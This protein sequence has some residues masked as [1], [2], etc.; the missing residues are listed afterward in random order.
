MARGIA[1]EIQA[2]LTP[3]EQARLAKARPVNPVAYEA[4][5]RGRLLWSKWSIEEA[6]KALQYFQQ[7]VAID[8]NY[9]QAY[10]GVSD[11]YR[12]LALFGGPKPEAWQKAKAAAIRAVE[13][14]ETL[15]EAHRSLAPILL[16]YD[17]D[18]AAS[19]REN[20]RALQLNPGDAETYRVYGNF[21]L[22]TGQLNEAI[23]MTKHAQELDPLSLITGADLG[24]SYYFA[25]RYD[26][27][28]KQCRRVVDL[29]PNFA[30]AHLW[31]GHA[32]EAERKFPEAIAEFKLS[33]E[34]SPGNPGYLGN[35]ARV[36]AVAAKTD[37]AR[38]ILAQLKE[39]SKTRYVAPVQFALIYAALG[40]KDQA[41]AWLEKAFGERS[42]VFMLSI[43]PWFDPLRSDPR[44]ADLT[45]RVGLAVRRAENS[46]G[47]VSK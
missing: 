2:K 35:L 5:L 43:A 41:F 46:A 25:R 22:V 26:E 11:S 14:D 33:V 29:D 10:S 9:A 15:A 3:E 4:Y 39:Q 21:F 19:E 1:T 47:K 13:L 34:L 32:Y 23:A 8:P 16:R 37:E 45:R 18:W 17:W 44:F 30:L 24:E 28:I 6:N 38:R 31:L 40:D 36:Y 20:Q 42:G 7:A 12:I 27:A